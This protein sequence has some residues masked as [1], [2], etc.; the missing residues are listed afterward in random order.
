MR[1]PSICKGKFLARPNRFIAYVETDE[2]C[3]ECHVKTTGRCRELLVPDATVVLAAAAG[4]HRRT[5]L[6]LIAVY[7]GKH[8]V[9][10]DSQAPNKLFS[11]WIK[12]KGW[13][14]GI[15]TIRPEYTYRTSRFDFY[16]ERGS[17]KIL[18]EVKGVT[19]E[20]NGIALFPDAPTQRGVRHLRE[21]TE[22]AA[23][24]Y[25]THMVFVIQMAHAVRFAPNVK[26]HSEFGEA[27]QIAAESG[28][29]LLAL[30]CQVEERE[31]RVYKEIPLQL[32][33]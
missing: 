7:K 30:N 11:E 29:N 14:G 2:G 13:M 8:L 3:K 31:I 23:E 17:D 25:E 16:L 10:I 21:L 18:V 12:E 32:T 28:V 5:N 24:G 1:Y 20:E 19:L 22:A 33:E 9:N 27:L 4:K 15:T 26:A 6:D